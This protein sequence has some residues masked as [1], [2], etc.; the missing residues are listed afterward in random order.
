[1]EKSGRRIGLYVSKDLLEEAEIARKGSKSG[2]VPRSGF[3]ARAIENH[4]E[5]L[6]ADDTE[7]NEKIE[8]LR[9]AK[10]V[11]E[12]LRAARRKNTNVVPLKKKE[13]S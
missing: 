11:Q 4:I 3:F 9:A 7:L 6:C 13:I 2:V 8:E 10:R 12:D 5:N 1:M